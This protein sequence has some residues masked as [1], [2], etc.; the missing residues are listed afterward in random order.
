[1]G[2][3]RGRPG[4]GSERR[5][6]ISRLYDV[7]SRTLTEA[8]TTIIRIE[9]L[10]AKKDTNRSEGP[11]RSV[12]DDAQDPGLEPEIPIAFGFGNSADEPGWSNMTIQKSGRP[13]TSLL[14]RSGC[15]CGMKS[16]TKHVGAGGM[17]RIGGAYSRPGHATRSRG[18]S[19]EIGT[20]Q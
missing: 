17:N 18:A 20:C 6:V 14:T 5:R 7:K 10:I 3:I 15:T 19:R 11:A 12:C 9:D 16:R 2:R 8:Q 1:M 13:D 4:T